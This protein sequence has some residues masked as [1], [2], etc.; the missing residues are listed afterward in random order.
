MIS[1]RYATPQPRAPWNLE[2]HIARLVFTEM[3]NESHVV[4]L[5]YDEVVAV[6]M[7][8][9]GKTIGSITTVGG[10]TYSALV[11][12]D[13]SYEGDLMAMTPG[14]D[15]TYGREPL[16]QYNESGA[17]SQGPWLPYGIEYG[18]HLPRLTHTHTHTHTHYIKRSQC[19]LKIVVSCKL[20]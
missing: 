2:P 13:A 19:G 9:Q 6:S 12:V 11:F 3:L 8:T 17:G 14:V 5:P 1:K 18:P 10:A 4:M 7:A 15:Y 20:E 16:A